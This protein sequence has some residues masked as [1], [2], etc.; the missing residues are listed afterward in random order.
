VIFLIQLEEKETTGKSA[1][2][3]PNINKEEGEI[4]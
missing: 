4:C 2:L 1:D 3:Q